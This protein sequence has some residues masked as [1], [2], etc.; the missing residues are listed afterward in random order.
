MDEEHHQEEQVHVVVGGKNK[1]DDGVVDN[2]GASGS[3]GRK[4][5]DASIRILP[6]D[7]IPMSL[8]EAVR[9]LEYHSSHNN[10][11][12]QKPHIQHGGS[13][14]IVQPSVAAASLSSSS[15]SS[16]VRSSQSTI[17]SNYESATTTPPETTPIKMTGPETNKYPPGDTRPSSSPSPVVFPLV[18]IQEEY[19]PDG[20]QVYG[21]AVDVSSRLRSLW[22]EHGEMKTN[23]DD[24]DDDDG[25]A[26][27]VMKYINPKD[28]S[29]HEAA[30]DALPQ[31]GPLDR[32]KAGPPVVS[33][34]EYERISRRLEELALLEES[35]QRGGGTSRIGRPATTKGPPPQQQYRKKAPSSSSSSLQF[36]RG[37][38]NAKPKKE[39]IPNKTPP[40]SSSS[41]TLIGGNDNETG[42]PKTVL[43]GEEE[44]HRRT[45]TI[46]TTRNTIQEIPRVG[47][48]LPVPPKQQQ[49]E[50]NS[51]SQRQQKQ[52]TSGRPLVDPKVFSGHI[53]ERPTPA[54]TSRRRQMTM[55]N[56]DDEIISANVNP[57]RLNPSGS[58]TR[59]KRTSWFAQ[60]RMQQQR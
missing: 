42:R 41:E 37:F 31:A 10:K 5:T 39:R 26:G 9:W 22:K 54:A 51:I 19:T 43:S 24:D 3:G 50:Q 25:D 34:E 48:Q 18:D 17:L 15:S 8:S 29:T 45:I 27:D 7:A 59:P 52:Q 20:R 47:R 38:L 28:D 11:H 30:D 4:E 44:P 21:K 2:A 46:D 16:R 35:Q 36:K 56:D 40:P 14:N 49:A 60:E 58:G 13:D 1:R 33:D 32:P 6:K 55:G 12:E 57:V 53:Q 23:H